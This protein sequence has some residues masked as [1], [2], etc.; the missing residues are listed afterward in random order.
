[1][2]E[3]ALDLSFGV[4]IKAPLLTSVCLSKSHGLSLLQNFSFLRGGLDKAKYPAPIRGLESWHMHIH[5]HP[6]THL[7]TSEGLMP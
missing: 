2:E 1:M 7:C 6:P 4:G 5:T 3:R